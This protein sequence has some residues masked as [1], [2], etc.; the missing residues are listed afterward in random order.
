MTTSVGKPNRERRQRRRFGAGDLGT[1][2]GPGA[3]GSRAAA[4]IDHCRE[5][6]GCSWCFPHGPETTNSTQAS[7]ARTWKRRRQARYRRS[8]GMVSGMPRERAGG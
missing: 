8:S 3:L 4:R 6:G 2:G 7:S 1:T 5:R